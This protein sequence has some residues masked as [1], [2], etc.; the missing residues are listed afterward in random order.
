MVLS[1]VGA[2]QIVVQI[3]EKDLGLIALG[4]PAKVS[5]DAYPNTNF[6]ASVV[7]INP[8]IDLQRGSVE[9][10]LAVPDPP[11][12]LRQDMTVSVDIEV[13]R[14]KDALTVKTTSV[15]DGLTR[16]P[17]LLIARSG[18]AVRQSVMIGARGIL[19]LEIA[20]GAAAGDLVIPASAAIAPGD[21]VRVAAP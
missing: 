2:I 11:A 8:S 18:R 1:P 9:I 10:K 5:A 19:D 6:P 14:R 3:D 15:H 16:T 20:S 17:W 12:T 13:A 21:K 4:Q 7:Y